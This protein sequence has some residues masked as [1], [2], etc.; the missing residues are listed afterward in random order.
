MTITQK[1]WRKAKRG[2]RKAI[3]DSEKTACS[4]SIAA[5]VLATSAYQQ[6]HTIGAYLC[7]PEEV[8]VAA[9]IQAAW[10]DGKS[11]YLPVVMELGQPLQFAPYHP[12]ASL[13]KDI[14]DIEIPAVSSEHYIEAHQLDVVVTP[15]VA[16]D[17]NR[18]RIGMGGGFYDRTFAFKAEKKQLSTPTLIGVAFEA[19]KIDGDIPTNDWDIRPD[20]IVSERA[21]YC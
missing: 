15:L 18:N 7:L 4:E 6:A 11:V 16:F 19:Q 12:D 2:A 20:M 13:S 17:E 10:A 9:I 14:L 21:T 1:D 3:S 8:S 5:A